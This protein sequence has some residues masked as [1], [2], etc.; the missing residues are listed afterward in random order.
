MKITEQQLSELTKITFSPAEISKTDDR[1]RINVLEL[2]EV[3]IEKIVKF[4]K[5]TDLKYY[6]EA[7]NTV[8]GCIVSV[9]LHQN[10]K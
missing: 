1:I 3:D 4:C 9:I 2:Y 6:I 10:K 7:L 8:N 5:E